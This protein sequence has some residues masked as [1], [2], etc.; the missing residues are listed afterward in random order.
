MRSTDSRRRG[1][2]LVELLVVI[3]IIGVL[4]GLLLP[5]VQQAREAARRMACSNNFKQLGLAIH[6]YASTYSDNLPQHKG[7]TTRNNDSMVQIS[8][9]LG[10]GVLQLQAAANA[11]GSNPPPTCVVGH[12]D[13][14][15]SILVP[16]LPFMEQQ[17]LWENVSNPF[18]GR[19]FG[20]NE[21]FVYA[22]AGGISPDVDV[23]M[24]LA[25]GGA[26]TPW[27][28]ELPVL[29]CPSDPGQG[30]PASGRTNYAAC[31]GD[32]VQRANRGGT[33]DGNSE[34]ANAWGLASHGTRSTLE[35]AR[36][37]KAS[38][39]GA[40]VPKSQTK[41][42][43]ILD[44]LSNT[45]FMTEIKTDIEDGDINTL[46]ASMAGINA[47][48]AGNATD[49]PRLN[50]AEAYSAQNPN[51]TAFWADETLAYMTSVAESANIT[52]PGVEGKRGLKWAAGNNMHTGVMTILPP[53]GPTW[54]LT[55][56]TRGWD[57]GAEMLVT[58]GARHQGGCHVLMGDGAVKFINETIDTGN[59]FSPTVHVNLDGSRPAANS[60]GNAVPAVGSISPYGV[61]G[62]MGTRA[63]K[64]II[65]EDAF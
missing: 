41:L 14:E 63:N 16:M 60:A 10:V 47:A 31:I 17:A 1:F 6:N 5:A 51:R 24:W 21:I 33:G 48:P 35:Y 46:P 59:R 15:L 37:V 43:S 23:W 58:A 34:D 54:S 26:Y 61:W 9:P 40:F 38:M 36:Q 53:N 65:G 62:A 57:T 11:C 49:G 42:S 45:I 30:L 3:A 7:G 27:V 44:G 29:R 20:S 2:T 52:M 28:T 19:R 25:L 12:A 64:E 50:P 8:N 4:V 56:D 18:P 32:G 55:D 22:A 39:R 13:G